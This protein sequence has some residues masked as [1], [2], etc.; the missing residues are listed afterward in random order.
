M[1]YFP[2]LSSDE[3]S[4]IGDH[5]CV[6]I[7]RYSPHNVLIEV[8]TF[9]IGNRISGS[10]FRVISNIKNRITTGKWDSFLLGHEGIRSHKSCSK[11]LIPTLYPTGISICAC[12]SSRMQVMVTCLLQWPEHSWMFWMTLLATQDFNCAHALLPRWMGLDV[13][14]TMVVAGVTQSSIPRQ[15]SHATA[16]TVPFKQCYI[17]RVTT[18]LVAA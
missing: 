13:L 17:G 10:Y 11:R 7:D 1:I 5:I 15:S 16:H 2:R 8:S 18:P 3:F 9:V 14:L 12:Q 6:L 4:H